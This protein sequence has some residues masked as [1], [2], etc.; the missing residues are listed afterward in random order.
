LRLVTEADV[1][2]DTNDYSVDPTTVRRMLDV[3][4]LA[5]VLEREESAAPAG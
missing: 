3:A 4:A 2:L 1:R 5:A